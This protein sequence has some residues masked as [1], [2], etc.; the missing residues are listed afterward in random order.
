MRYSSSVK[1]LIAVW[2]LLFGIGVLTTSNGL[3]GTLLGLRANIEGFPV[4]MTGV[5]MAMYYAGFLL[6]CRFVPSMIASVGHVRVFAA[7]ASIAS[8]TVL[9]HGL[10]VSPWLWIPIR[11]ITGFCFSGLFIIAESWLNRIANKQQ[12]GTIFSAYVSIVYGGLFCGQF[13]INI[14]PLTQIDLFIVVSVL[15]SCALAPITL[16][17]KRMPG[18]QKPETLPFKDMLKISPLAMAGV[19][20]AGLCSSTLL[21]LGPVYA[22]KVDIPTNDIALFMGIYILGNTLMPMVIGPIS[23]KFDRRLVI[24]ACVFVGIASALAITFTTHYYALIFILGG[25]ITTLYS[26]SIT[27]MND[28]IKKSQIVS[29]SRSLIMFNAIGST[30]GPLAGGFILSHYAPSYIFA[31]LAFYLCVLMVIAIL[32]AIF[33]DTIERKHSFVSMPAFSAPSVM[34]LWKYGQQ[35][36]KAVD[37]DTDEPH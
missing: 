16:T 21:S 11:L 3:Q 37:R 10:F 26:L 31:A 34:R 35:Q 17:N 5:I 2:P 22:D 24:K 36:H 13:M 15:I 18:Y 27:H 29:A 1:R 30:I 33:G 32:R 4:E 19:F 9:L 7:M 12:R 14:A 28:Q 25:T 8:T 20:V 23:D 6:G